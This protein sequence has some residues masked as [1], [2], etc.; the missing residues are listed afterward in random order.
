LS[1]KIVKNRK[2]LQN[3]NF[4]KKYVKKNRKKSYD[5][6]KKHA[7]FAF[8]IGRREGTIQPCDRP[9]GLNIRI[10]IDKLSPAFSGV[11]KWGT[12]P[13]RARF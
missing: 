4:T 13:P 6:T 12:N 3:K 1:R 8:L 10:T 9:R 7:F 5:F 2:N 11:R